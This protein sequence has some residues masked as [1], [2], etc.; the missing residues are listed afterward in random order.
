MLILFSK[1][2]KCFHY[3]VRCINEEVKYL[4]VIILIQI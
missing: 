1:L 2:C 3:P 4:F